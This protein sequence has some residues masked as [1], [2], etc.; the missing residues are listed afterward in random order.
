MSER[1][2]GARSTSPSGT[3]TAARSTP[4][5]SV[6]ALGSSLSLFLALSFSLCVGFGL[7]FPAQAMFQSWF[8]LLP[9]FTWLSWQ[10]FLIGLVDS[11]AYGWYIALVFGPIYNYFSARNN[12]PGRP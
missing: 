12:R 2:I 9:G 7:L 3:S 10:T 8:R 11:A 1:S 4:R 5:L 6:V